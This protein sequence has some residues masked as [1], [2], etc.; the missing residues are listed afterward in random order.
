[1]FSGRLGVRAIWQI[2]QIVVGPWVI[3]P[4]R[5]RAI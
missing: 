4:V 1:M 3:V 5:L 2:M